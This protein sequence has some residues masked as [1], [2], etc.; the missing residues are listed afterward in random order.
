MYKERFAISW[1][2]AMSHRHVRS[3]HLG[4]HFVNPTTF[5]NQNSGYDDV[6]KSFLRDKEIDEDARKV[7][8][9]RRASAVSAMLTAQGG[10]AE[11]NR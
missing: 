3:V 2:F 4:R 7:E 10:K 5:A 8:R 6:A 1:K 9:L 11:R